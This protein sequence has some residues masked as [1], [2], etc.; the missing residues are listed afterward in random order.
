MW[1]WLL[2]IIRKENI[3]KEERRQYIYYKYL[4]MVE[5]TKE[6]KGKIEKIKD[7]DEVSRKSGEREIIE[8]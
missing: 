6:E 8:K 5:N 1:R 4:A 2:G 3:I 7:G